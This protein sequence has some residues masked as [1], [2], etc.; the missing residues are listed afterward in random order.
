[1]KIVFVHVTNWKRAEWWDE[2][3]ARPD[4]PLI[5]A[6]IDFVLSYKEYKELLERDRKDNP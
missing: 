3:A 1:M 2:V 4:E 5:E 6:K